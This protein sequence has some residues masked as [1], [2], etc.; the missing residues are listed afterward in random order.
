[1]SKLAI[2][3]F[4]LGGPDKPESVKPFLFNLFNDPEI[5]SFPMPA[6]ARWALARMISTRRAPTSRG[7]YAHLG[8]S[9]PLLENTEAQARALESALVEMLPPEDEVKAFIAMRYWHPMSAETA[10]AVADYAPDEIVLLPLYPQYSVTTTGSSLD[11]WRRAAD[12][13]GLAAPTRAVCCYPHDDGFISGAANLVADALPK[14]DG[15][16]NPIRLLF[17]A[18]GLPERIIKGGDPYQWQVQVTAEAILGELERRSD[19][20]PFEPILCYQSKVGPLK[21]IGPSTE[22]EIE[23]AGADGCAVVIVPI[24]FV[25]EH[26]ETLVELDIEYGEVAEHSGAQPYVRVPTVSVNELFVIGLA[27]LALEARGRSVPASS[28]LGPRICPARFGRCPMR[29][30]GETQ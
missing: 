23:R 24:A 3:L 7:I 27:K 17:S 22:D 12:E 26:L 15:G 6:F 29:E 20:P 10:R 30:R 13:A 14:A 19:L 18:H 16:G 21:W 8:G 9:S 2:V 4:N 11:D 28:A 5:I 25:S 1:M